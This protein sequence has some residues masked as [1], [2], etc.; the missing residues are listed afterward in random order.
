MNEK[1]REREREKKV[2]IDADDGYVCSAVILTTW[3]EERN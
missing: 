1:T 3:P 2:C